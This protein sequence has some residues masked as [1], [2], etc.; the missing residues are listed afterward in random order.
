MTAGFDSEDDVKTSKGNEDNLDALSSDWVRFSI[1]VPMLNTPGEK[2]AY[3]SMNTFLLG[4]ILE[5]STGEKFE[6]FANKNLFIPLDINNVQWRKAP[7]GRTVA[8]GNFMISSRDMGKFAQLYLN[9][10]IYKGKRIISKEWISESTKGVFPVHWNNLDTYG[11]QWYNHTL[12]INGEIIPYVIASGNG[13]NKIYII[14]KYNLI[15]TVISTAYGKKRGHTRSL[16]ILKKVLNSLL[17]HSVM[18]EVFETKKLFS[19]KGKQAK[20]PH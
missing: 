12:N 5:K 7:K 18:V 16:E 19:Y 15:V 10:G 3:S 4:Y 20:H 9:N 6:E 1:D 14:T 13:G 2:W 11:F 17:N 8:Q